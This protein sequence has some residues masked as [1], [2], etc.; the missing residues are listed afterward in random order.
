VTVAVAAEAVVVVPPERAREEQ[1]RAATATES[2]PRSLLEA[3]FANSVPDSAP[4]MVG[5]DDATTTIAEATG[6]DAVYVIVGGDDIASVQN[7]MLRIAA[8][9]D[10]GQNADEVQKERASRHITSHE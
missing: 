6:T 7:S 2:F 3:K 10:R 1:R 5:D 4:Y 9:T 8:S